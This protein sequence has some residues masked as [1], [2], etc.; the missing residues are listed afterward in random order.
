MFDHVY[1]IHCKRL[2]SRRNYLLPILGDL[3]WKARWI[4]SSDPGEIPRRHLLRVR[5]GSPILSVGEISVYLKHLEAFRNIAV[6]KDSVGLVIEDDVVFPPDFSSTFARY[7]SS[8][9]LPFDMVFFGASETAG[10]PPA[11]GAG[12]F[13]EQP[14]TRSMSG[15]LITQRAA[16]RLFAELKDLPVLE[17]IDHAVN[18]VLSSGGF[19]VLW[20]RPPLLLN[21]S[22][23]KLFG[24]SLGVPW[25][26]GGRRTKLGGRA[27]L[28]MDRLLA[29]MAVRH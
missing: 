10:H 3:G 1:V 5:L 2:V 23:T 24:H 12:L 22:E 19:T 21:G 7:C 20:S 25:R 28:V 9:P 14:S 4:D 26:E 27:K 6:A 8:I 18:R 17:P 16:S 29:A 13:L 15:Y 11:D